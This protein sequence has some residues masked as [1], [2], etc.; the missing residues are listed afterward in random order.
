MISFTLK[1]TH[2]AVADYYA[3]L[4]G[5][6]QLS[7]FGEGAVAPAF[8]N[9]LRAATRGA[10][11]TLGEQYV[12]KRG[13]RVI[14]LDGALLDAFKLP[15]GYW[16]AKDSADDLDGEIKKKFQ[17]GYPKENIIFQAPERAVVVQDGNRVFDGPITQPEDLVEALRVFF[18]YQP[19]AFE[20]WQEAVGEFKNEVPKLAQALIDLIERERRANKKFII[21]FDN[22]AN[23]CR[24]T[25]NPNLADQA[26]EEMLIQHLLTERIFRRVFNNPDFVNR[27]AIAAEIE[28]VIRALTSQQFSRH[29]FFKPLD[30]FYGAIESTAATIEDFS[31]KQDFLN[32]VYENFFQGFSV[33]VADTHGIVYTPQPIVD[34]M[35]RSVDVLLQRE[36]G[37]GLA[38]PGVHVLD[39]FVGTGNFILRVMRHLQ[40]EGKLSRLPAKYADALHCNEVMLLPYY[41]AAMNIEH[42]YFE[43]TGEYV[44]F[45]GICLVDTFDLAEGLQPSLFA[46]ENTERVQRQQAADITVVIGN[47]PYNAWQ[48]NENDNN[49]NRS[50]P[51]VDKRVAETY[52]AASKATNKNALS[53]PYVK[54]FRWASDRIGKEGIVAYISNGSYVDGLSFDGMRRCLGEEFDAVY[55]LDLGGNVRK[56]P[57]L[58]GTT[59]NVFGIQVGVS[60]AFLVRRAEGLL[61]A[62]KRIYYARVD[63]FWRKGQKYDFLDQSRDVNGVKWREIAP[64]SNHTWLTEGMEDEFDAFLPIGTK[65]AK[66]GDENAIFENYGRGVATSRDAWAFNFDRNGLIENIRRMIKTYNE[67]VMRWD[68]SMSKLGVDEFVSNNEHEISWSESLKSYL[69]ARVTLSFDPS[70]IR[71]AYYRPFTKQYLYFDHHLDERRYQFPY[72]LPTPSSEDENRVIWLKVGTGWTQFAMMVD[73]IANLLPQSGSQCFPFYTYDE[74]GSHRRENI[75]DWALAQFQDHYADPSIDKWAIFHYVYALLHHPAYREKY[76]ANLRRALPRLPFAPDFHAFAQAGRALADLHVHYEAQPEYALDWVETKG[77]KL[78]FAVHKMKLAKDKSSM[79]YNDFLTL[80]GLPPAIFDYKLGNRSA[81]EWIIDRYQVSVDKRSGIVNDPNQYSDDPRY[82]VKL[83]GQVVHVSVET[84]KIVAG[85]PEME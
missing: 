59:H 22:F 26:V 14:R 76:A 13:G 27:N 38:D 52:A 40:E 71:H 2:K 18:T 1:P 81:L 62:D 17:V 7:L 42:E 67:H 41:I 73:K 69:Q 75:T 35:V 19:P 20:R 21:A 83:I 23:L 9:L 78:N 29:D 3:E 47:P 11:L 58:S 84:V 70:K 6:A 34:F 79:R 43:M 85:L 28:T 8:A 10:D 61:P 36:F 50:Y 60:I 12:L 66:A 63:E 32:T 24:E 51:V 82:I 55:V 16:E 48:V 49:K 39:P 57:K 72:F 15:Y 4:E 74:D 64:N 25:I 56:N 37:R 31:Q 77:A 33:K 54:A 44:P 45:P 68:Q 65:E 5:L 53:D 46:P 80:A 30:R